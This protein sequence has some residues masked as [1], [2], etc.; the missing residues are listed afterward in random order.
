MTWAGSTLVL[1]VASLRFMRYVWRHRGEAPQGMQR[2]DSD[3]RTGMGRDADWR[4]HPRSRT[5]DYYGRRRSQGHLPGLPA[6]MAV[7]PRGVRTSTRGGPVGGDLHPRERSRP[8][9]CPAPAA[10]ARRAQWTPRARPATLRGICLSAAPFAAGVGGVGGE[11]VD[12][13]SR[14]PRPLVHPTV[15]FSPGPQP[16]SPL[17]ATTCR[18][19]P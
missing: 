4:V 10:F 17:R 2:S 7:R 19:A 15:P 8:D 12:G 1:T 16:D 13:I 3:D 11:R 14:R 6:P 18:E 9:V 5:M